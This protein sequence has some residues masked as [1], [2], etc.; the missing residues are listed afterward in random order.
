MHRVTRAILLLILLIV[1]EG[2]TAPLAIGVSPALARDTAEPIDAGRLV[3]VNELLD[4]LAAIGFRGAVL[5]AQGNEIALAQGYGWAD[6]GRTIPIE[7]ET[8]FAI[9]SNTKPFTAAAILKLQDDGLLNVTDT[10]DQFLPDV[11]KDKQAITIHQLLTHS[12]GLDHSGIFAGDFE[13]IDRDAAVARIL[14]SDL[15]FAPGSASSYADASMILLA[16]IVE[17]VTG[18]PYEAFLRQALFSPAGMTN[19]GFR[20]DDPTLVGKRQ[21]AGIVGGDLV[22]TPDD[23]PP[24]T[25]AVKG[26]GGMLSSVADLFRWHRAVRDGAI[27]TPASAEAYATGHVPLE[28]GVSEGY[29]WVVAEP[30][31]GHRLRT[32]AGGTDEI[33]HVN[34]VDWW[35][36]DDLVV[37][38]SSAD[39]AYNAEAINEAIEKILLGLP[40]DLPPLM[41]AVDEAE[42]R[43]H[44][45]TYD[46]PAGG[47]LIVTATDD[48]LL[49]SPEGRNGF[50]TLCE[51][52]ASLEDDEAHQEAIVATMTYLR[53]GKEAGLDAW[54]EEQ[55]ALLGPFQRMSV[56]GIASPE[57]GEEWTYVAF[58]FAEGSVLTRWI[59]SE[60]GVL[61]AAVVPSDPPTMMLLPTSRSTFAPFAI[62]E[63]AQMTV[64]FNVDA[65]GAGILRLQSGTDETVTAIRGN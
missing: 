56:M 4:R 29:G 41:A 5:I 42:L 44:A 31:P 22:G 38:T 54:R 47:A 1:F 61:D 15:L 52:A 14:A 59:V 18:Q 65:T 40:Q 48:R 37:I 64:E 20:G 6:P 34:V 8:I 57:G 26:A 46:L 55:E 9:G 19:T 58:N 51:E 10:I 53:S 30:I 16:A 28:P 62:S 32:S 11:P 12:A 60:N 39:A 13:Q 49:I 24:L 21:A 33:G 36:D 2:G 27:L 23:L 50:A 25:W 45:G 17:Y 7:P 35:L 43:S 3:Q 63:P